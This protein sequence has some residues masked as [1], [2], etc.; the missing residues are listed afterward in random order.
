MKKAKVFFSV[1]AL[2]FFGIGCATV[3]H[4]VRQNV[5]INSDPSGATVKVNGYQGTTPST[6][7]LKRN[8]SYTVRVE[9][10][11]YT[12]GVANIDKKLSPWFWGN[13]LLGGLPGMIVDAI[14]GAMWDLH[15]ES[16][17][18]TLQPTRK[19]EKKKGEPAW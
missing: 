9:K 2:V 14:D 13:C 15:P 16:V 5:S 1:L 10:E 4:G 19:K 18:V 6:M 12:E 3:G 17:N 7:S 11:G 8:K